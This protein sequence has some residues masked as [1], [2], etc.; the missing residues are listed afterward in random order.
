MA[1]FFQFECRPYI[2]GWIKWGILKNAVM[3]SDTEVVH[4]S[5]GTETKVVVKGS[6]H[7]KVIT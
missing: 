7:V 6:C 4:S 5:N 2:F 3:D 1:I